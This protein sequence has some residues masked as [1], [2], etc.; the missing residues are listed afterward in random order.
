[1][2]TVAA[3]AA[4]KNVFAANDEQITRALSRFICLSVT[5]KSFTIF[6]VFFLFMY[7]QII[8]ILN[9]DTLFLS[10]THSEIVALRENKLPRIFT[11]TKKMLLTS[12]NYWRIMKR[13]IF[14][15]LFLGNIHDPGH[16]NDNVR[17]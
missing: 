5:E 11:I 14:I 8:L 1:M 15:S 17:C 2:V 6:F 7:M 16:E 3:V 9:T 10:L 4:L 13:Y 12:K